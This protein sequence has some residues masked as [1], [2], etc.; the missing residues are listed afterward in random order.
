MLPIAFV[1][2]TVHLLSVRQWG[3]PRSPP[4]SW[5]A[6]WHGIRREELFHVWEVPPWRSWGGER[7][8]EHPALEL[9]FSIQ[10]CLTQH[11]LCGF[12]VAGFQGLLSAPGPYKGFFEEKF[13]GK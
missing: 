10:G 1:H 12:P 2:W 4:I 8:L 3:G 9:S 5:G 6:I 7:L 11:F 13:E